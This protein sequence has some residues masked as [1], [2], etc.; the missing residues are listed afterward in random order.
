ML[1]K[2]CP[3]ISLKNHYFNGNVWFFSKTRK[4][5]CFQ[6][7]L[8]RFRRG[9]ICGKSFKYEIIWMESPA[10]KSGSRRLLLQSSCTAKCQL[11]SQDCVTWS[12]SRWRCVWKQV[13]DQVLRSITHWEVKININ[14]YNKHNYFQGMTKCN[15]FYLWKYIKIYSMLSKLLIF[16]WITGF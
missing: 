7:L 14:K 2:T 3:S 4:M 12:H 11:S 9:E 8:W 10:H 5:N 15:E 1:W 13:T 16:A 6:Q